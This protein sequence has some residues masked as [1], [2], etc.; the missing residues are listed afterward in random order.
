M[1]ARRR[2]HYAGDYRLRRDRLMW[3]IASGNPRLAYAEVFGHR[4]DLEHLAGLDQVVCWRCGEPLPTCGPNR[5]GRHRTG[6]R[7]HWQA[8]HTTDG[9]STQPIVPEC[10]PCNA[11]A[12]AAAGNRRRGPVG[13]NATSR[14]W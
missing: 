3:A 11:S 9:D 12:G 1:P 4:P 10:S 5:N 13:S 8:G 6:K 2:D 14:S 7:A